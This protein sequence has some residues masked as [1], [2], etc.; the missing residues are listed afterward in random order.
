MS[1]FE[2]DFDTITDKR[3]TVK[4]TVTASRQVRGDMVHPNTDYLIINPSLKDV[5]GSWEIETVKED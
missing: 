2:L 1:D 4:E 3:K 5:E